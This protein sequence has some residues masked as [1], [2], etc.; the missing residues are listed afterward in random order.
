MSAKRLAACAVFLD[1]LQLHDGIEHAHGQ[2]RIGIPADGEHV[3]EHGSF[4][5]GKGG[6][7]R[8]VARWQ[9][10][11]VVHRRGFGCLHEPA[12]IPA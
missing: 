12:G 2:A 11:E 3:G 6:G 9:L 8:F 5:R 1:F 10:P 7:E 4:R